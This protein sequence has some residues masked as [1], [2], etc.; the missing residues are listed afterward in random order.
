M[1]SAFL[2]P[3]IASILSIYRRAIPSELGGIALI[4]VAFL[5]PVAQIVQL[6]HIPPQEQPQT[7]TGQIP[8]LFVDCG[9]DRHRDP[10]GTRR[11]FDLGTAHRL[12]G[13]IPHRQMAGYPV[14]VALDP[15]D[16]G[17]HPIGKDLFPVIP[18]VAVVIQRRT[19]G[20][21]LHR[22]GQQLPTVPHKGYDHAAP[23]ADGNGGIAHRKDKAVVFFLYRAFGGRRQR[24][25]RLAKR[26]L[27]KA[28]LLPIPQNVDIQR[29][30]IPL[31]TFGFGDRYGAALPW[32]QIQGDLPL[33]QHPAVV[34]HRAAKGVMLI[35]RGKIEHVAEDVAVLCASDPHR[36]MDIFGVQCPGVQPPIR[37]HHAVDAEVAVIDQLTKVA[38]IGVFRLSVSGI[39]QIDALIA[40]LPNE[41][42]GHGIVSVDQ[43]VIDLQIAGAVAHGMTVFA[44]DQRTTVG[45]RLALRVVPHIFIGRVHF[46]YRI[47]FM[48]AL[49]V[50]AVTEALVMCGA[51]GIQLFDQPSSRTQV[52]AVA[53][54]VAQRPQDHA[55][56]VHIPAHQQPLPIQNCIGKP[57]VLCDQSDPVILVLPFKGVIYLYAAVRFQIGLINYIEAQLIAQLV[58]LRRIGIVGGA[59]GVQIQALHQLKITAHGLVGAIEAAFHIKIMAVHALQLD[60]T[61]IEPQS[62]VFDLDLADADLFIEDL[63]SAQDLQPVQAGR[64]CRPALRLLHSKRNCLTVLLTQQLTG[65]SEQTHGTR[66]LAVDL[67]M[68]ISVRP[69][70]GQLRRYT[71]IPYRP[72]F[73]GQDV[74][75]TENAGHPPFI[76]ILQIGAVTIFQHHD[77]DLVVPI[78]QILG[79][80]EFAGR[81]R[82]L[83]VSDE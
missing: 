71:I 31:H 9:V 57:L 29:H 18:D 52:I 42:P 81:M 64:F 33:I 16:L 54:L 49:A 36:A 4:D 77:G 62:T 67:H 21:E 44:Y 68:D 35:D 6:L 66:L 75:L 5:R 10:A 63:I 23:F 32:R 58:K 41:R 47:Q 59:H 2:R 45:I 20:I 60:S 46:G 15:I 24:R 74:H 28:D 79:D 72:V 83:T 40:P 7:K 1:R 38:A 76:L 25:L 11:I 22:L 53:A 39:A 27:L 34:G 26:E 65:R 12:V 69:I 73:T 30:M 61:T 19:V 43:L 37:Q 13:G 82:Y 78:V 50:Q 8:Q 14:A 70:I 17:D 48:L 55:W 80:V 56:A 3:D 51:G